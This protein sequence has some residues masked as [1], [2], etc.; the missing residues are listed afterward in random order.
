MSI[1]LERN[2]IDQYEHR[3]RRH[4]RYVPSSMLDKCNGKADRRLILTPIF[5]KRLD[6]AEWLH[7]KS[8]R[9]HNNLIHARYPKLSKLDKKK[10]P[11]Y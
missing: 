4:N 11:R 1:T 8:K 2:E 6:D 3:F 9:N 5:K 10:Y 7:Y